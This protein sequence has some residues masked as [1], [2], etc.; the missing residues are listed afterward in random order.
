MCSS[1]GRW[2]SHQSYQFDSLFQIRNQI[3]APFPDPKRQRRRPLPCASFG[4]HRL[5][6]FWVPRC[7][8]NSNMSPPLRNVKYHNSLY[9]YICL[10]YWGKKQ[11]NHLV[12]LCNTWRS[13]EGSEDRWHNDT[14]REVTSSQLQVWISSLHALELVL[15]LNGLQPHLAG[16][17]MANQPTPH[18]RYSFL[19]V[20]KA[21]LRACFS[22]W[23]PG[24]GGWPA[25]MIMVP[26]PWFLYPCI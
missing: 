24:G 8:N 16:D 1:L 12:S 2:V 3:W 11:M 5:E 21:V 6:S 4:D 26:Y 18:L 9:I 7:M 10:D 15:L 13:S 22:H 25:M 14:E 20:Y 19:E 17:F 23:F